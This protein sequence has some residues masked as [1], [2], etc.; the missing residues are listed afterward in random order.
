MR[1]GAYGWKHLAGYSHRMGMA[2]QRN[3]VRCH[4]DCKSAIG[5]FNSGI[6]HQVLCDRSCHS[7]LAV[8]CSQPMSLS[9]LLSAV[10][11]HPINA[12]VVRGLGGGGGAC[13]QK[14]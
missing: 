6:E 8:G 3:S 13:T 2:S 7:W 12:A 14:S 9:R 4:L 10:S 5:C 1:L 11:Q